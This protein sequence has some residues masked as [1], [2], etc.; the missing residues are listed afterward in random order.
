MIEMYLLRQLAGLSEY[1][2]LSEA[3]KHLHV[4]QPTLTRSIRKLE[5]LLGADLFHREKNRICINDT[6]RLAVEYAKRILA[7]EQE[8]IQAIQ[9]LE[10]GR[11]TISIAS[12]APAPNLIMKALMEKR[13]PQMQVAAEMKPEEELLDGL[14]RGEFQLVTLSGEVT[15]SGLCCQK[16]GTEHLRLSVLPAHPAAVMESV[17]FSDI[18]S[19]SYLVYRDLGVWEDI[20]R[21]YMP[22]AR[23]IFQNGMDEYLEVVRTSSLPT[24]DTDWGLIL[25]GQTANRVS[26]PIHDGAAK[27]TFFAVYQESDRKRFGELIEQVRNTFVDI[28]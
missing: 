6:G 8:M 27:R 9:A 20:G 18:N 14:K 2:T 7:S 16:I 25:Y 11:H 12:C 17:S 23:F 10:R 4:T 22:N 5:E 1:D 3:A 15:E 28:I 13:F 19:G 26:V 21:K 24:F